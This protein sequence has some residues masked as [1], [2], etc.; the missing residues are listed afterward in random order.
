MGCINDCEWSV[1]ETALQLYSHHFCAGLVI[2][3]D[4]V[5][6]AAPV[7]AYMRGWSRA[8]VE[9]YATRKRWKVEELPQEPTSFECDDME[10]WR[11]DFERENPR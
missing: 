5:K 8:K 9:H 4:K 11:Y 10:S 7:L 2:E 3:N 6:R 1:N